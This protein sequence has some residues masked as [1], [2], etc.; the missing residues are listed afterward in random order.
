M[1]ANAHARGIVQRAPG[2]G[3][4]FCSESKDAQR[5]ALARVTGRHLKPRGGAGPAS[6]RPF[7]TAARRARKPPPGKGWAALQ[8]GEAPLVNALVALLTK[9][10]R[11]PVSLSGSETESATLV[12][13]ISRC[14][15]RRRTPVRAAALVEVSL[16]A[17][18]T[19]VALRISLSWN[20]NDEHPGGDC[21]RG[22]EQR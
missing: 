19:W 15:A 4:R 7:V 3:F 11:R 14:E 12:T 1:Q 17:T 16:A 13:S 5:P 8:K 6:S 18:Q 21:Q 10:R 2:R 9:D 20:R 22:G